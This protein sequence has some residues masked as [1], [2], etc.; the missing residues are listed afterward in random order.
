[1]KTVIFVFVIYLISLKIVN[2][3]LRKFVATEKTKPIEI[4]LSSVLLS[5]GSGCESMKER[6]YGPRKAARLHAAKLHATD[7]LKKHHVA[8]N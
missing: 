1:M 4:I 3:G 2:K 8:L 6:I 5:E 7:F